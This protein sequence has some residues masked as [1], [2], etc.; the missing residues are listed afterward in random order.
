MSRPASC[1]AVSG[2]RPGTGCVVERWKN[3]GTI[4]TIPPT[5]TT[6][7]IS[8]IIRKLLVSIRSWPETGR[9]VL[10]EVPRGS[11]GCSGRGDD[12]GDRR[13]P[14]RRAAGAGGHHD[15]PGHQQHAAEIKQPADE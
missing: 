11:G 5:A 12:A 2:F 13:L 1:S 4:S 3:S 7:R 10:I 9:V 15:V 8:T 6:S 14:S